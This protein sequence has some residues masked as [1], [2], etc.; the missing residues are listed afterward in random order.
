MDGDRLF[1]VVVAVDD[2]LFVAVVVVSAGCCPGRHPDLVEVFVVDRLAGA[3]A[4]GLVDL[5][6]HLAAYVVVLLLV[7]DHRLAVCPV[8][9]AGV[10]AGGCLYAGVSFSSRLFPRCAG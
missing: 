10:V 7:V 3:F 1:W 6:H 5:S 9:F 8:G 2:C 4:A